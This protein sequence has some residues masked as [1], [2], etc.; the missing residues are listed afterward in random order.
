MNLAPF[1]EWFAIRANHDD[2]QTWP[3]RLRFDPS[4]G[5]RLSAIDFASG[6]LGQ[7]VQSFRA[8][9]ITGYLDYGDPHQARRA[10]QQ[11]YHP[12]SWQIIQMVPI[13]SLRT[14]CSGTSISLT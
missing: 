2:S 13:K 10:L 5:F 3:G 11:S 12:L 7:E 4:S 9:T 14:L 1:E 8:D 6:A